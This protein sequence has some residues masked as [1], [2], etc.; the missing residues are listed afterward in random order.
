MKLTAVVRKRSVLLE[1][2]E[3]GVVTIDASRY[4]RPQPFG[5][6]QCKTHF[7]KVD[8]CTTRVT[9]RPFLMRLS[10]GHPSRQAEKALLQQQSRH[11]LI[12]QLMTYSPNKTFSPYK[13]WCHRFIYL[14]KSWTIF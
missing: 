9:A 12:Q 2:M 5:R 7:F 8:L 4:V 1:A 11:D 6:S 14:K 3:E 13:L 10:L